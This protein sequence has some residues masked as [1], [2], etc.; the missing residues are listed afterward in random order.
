MDYRIGVDLGGPDRHA[1]ALH[2]S[3]MATLFLGAVPL[4][5]SEMLRVWVQYSRSPSRAARRAKRGHRQHWAW[6]PDPHAL[7]QRNPQG[8]IL[9]IVAH[10]VTAARIRDRLTILGTARTTSADGIIGGMPISAAIRPGADEERRILRYLEDAIIRATAGHNVRVDKLQANMAR[11]LGAKYEAIGER[12]QIKLGHLPDR[13]K[14]LVQTQV[15]SKSSDIWAAMSGNGFQVKAESVHPS[16]EPHAEKNAELIRWAFR[17]MPDFKFQAAR[18]IVRKTLHGWGVLVFDIFEDAFE[19]RAIVDGQWR[20]ERKVAYHGPRVKSLDAS[21]FI[22]PPEPYVDDIQDYSIVAE[23][24]RSVTLHDLLEG[25]EAGLYFDI[26]K[27]LNQ[28]RG[29]QG[30]SGSTIGLRGWTAELKLMDDG[31]DQAAGDAGDQTSRDLT[32]T[33]EVLKIHFKWKLPPGGRARRPKTEAEAIEG[34]QDPKRLFPYERHGAVSDL[35]AYV[36]PDMSMLIGLHDARTLFPNQPE[37]RPYL[38]HSMI[39]V[40][41]MHGMGMAD[42]LRTLEDDQ[43]SLWQHYLTSAALAAGPFVFYTAQSGFDPNTRIRPFASAAVVDPNSI[44]T[45]TFSGNIAPLM[46]GIE[47]MDLD[48]QRLTGQHDLRAGIPTAN[49][50]ETLGGQQLMQARGEVRTALDIGRE[51]AGWSQ[52]AQRVN[53]L[54]GSPYMPKEVIFRVSGGKPRNFHVGAGGFAIAQDYERQ[55]AYDY[56][57]TLADGPATLAQKH[58]RLLGVTQAILTLPVIQ[59]NLAAQAAIAKR[60]VMTAGDGFEDLA[61]LIVPPSLDMP[62]AISE[63]HRLMSEGTAVPVNAADQDIEHLNGSPNGEEGHYAFLLELQQREPAYRNLALE[64]RVL[65]HIATHLQQH[66]A[67]Q[68]AVSAA[69]AGIIPAGG[70]APG[71]E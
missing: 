22:T 57:L 21:L 59:Q 44:K 61:E 26:R 66:Q 23:R 43:S 19:S 30:E 37:R 56:T 39:D 25:E 12:D 45:V 20:S 13:R 3:S 6:R 48:A 35:V 49:Q 33:I 7:I 50:P 63:E 15:F 24:K 28:L 10:P 34:P 32:E 2:P 71:A 41:T 52:V 62:R 11:L 65:A 64:D 18:H 31:L 51:I 17:S 53:K 27:R 54:F 70:G 14:P 42:I 40:G 9:A 47:R 16:D 69:S 58:F 1:I 29:A 4:L 38:L 5:E 67:K 46:E 36:V 8:A 55:G 68:I 60:L